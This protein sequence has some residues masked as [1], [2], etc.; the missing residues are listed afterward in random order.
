VV[1]VHLSNFN[2]EEHRLPEDGHLAL[3]KLLERLAQDDYGGVV[4]VELGPEVLHAEDEAQV[5][6]H[7]RQIVAFCRRH[8]T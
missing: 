3:D 7:L 2:G 1:H 8:T 5:R 6:D 4:T